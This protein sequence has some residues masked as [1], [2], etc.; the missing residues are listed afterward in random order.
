MNKVKAILGLEDNPVKFH[1]LISLFVAID[2]IIS[3][4]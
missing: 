4:K 3:I 1:E 2:E